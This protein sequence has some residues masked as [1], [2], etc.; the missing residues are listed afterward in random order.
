MKSKIFLFIV[1][2]VSVMCAQTNSYNN[3]TLES[4]I[5]IALEQNKQNAISRQHL[6]IS[7]AQLKQAQSAKLPQVDLTSSAFV[8]DEN[9]TFVQPPMAINMPPLNLGTM[10][11]ILPTVELP[12]Q[13]FTLANNK[14]IQN[15]LSITYPLYTGGK[16]TAINEQ[17]KF[18]YEI[19]KNEATLTEK[20]I[21]YNVKNTFYAVILSRNLE[22]ISSDALQR[23]EAT[24]KLTESMFNAG[25]EKVNKLDYLKNKMTLEGFRGMNASMSTNYKSAI[26]ALKFYMGL[27]QEEEISINDLVTDY[28]NEQ[29]DKYL[30]NNTLLDSNVNMLKVNN[31]IKAFEHK[32]EEAKSDYYPSVAL[33]GNYRR[34]DNSYNYANFTKE[35]QNIFTLGVGLKWSLF[36]GYRTDGKVEE[37]EAELQKIQA[38]RNYLQDGLTM[39]KTKLMND[40]TEATEKIKALKDAVLTATENRELNLKAYQNDMAPVADF[41]QAQLFESIFTAQYE[42]ALYQR[43]STI[44]KLEQLFGEFN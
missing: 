6:Q 11:L 5:K 10:N 24:F 32:V 20:E 43:I 8:N 34:W 39:Q 29:I 17:A 33:F 15:E 14:S 42:M 9:I 23:F 7:K 41:I 21:V 40:L 19:A 44:I 25:S 30:S 22:K 38:Q 16:I 26:S 35:N 31:A 4:C 18:G 28:N 13:F 36:N 27:K 1:S 2:F 12:A 3:L 37:M